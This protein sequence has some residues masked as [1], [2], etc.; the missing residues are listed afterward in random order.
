MKAAKVFMPSRWAV[1]QRQD[2]QRNQFK[3]HHMTIKTLKKELP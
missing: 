1:M 2:T 3:L